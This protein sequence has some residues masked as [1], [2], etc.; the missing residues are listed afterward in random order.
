MSSDPH[1]AGPNA[2]GAAPGQSAKQPAAS[3]APAAPATLDLE[4]EAPEVPDTLPPPVPSPVGTPQ[5]AALDDLEEVDLDLEEVGEEELE[6][7]DL[8][9]SI[10][11]APVDP[12]V[13]PVPKPDAPAAAG[14]GVTCNHCGHVHATDEKFCDACGLRIDKIGTFAVEEDE[15]PLQIDEDGDKLLCRECGVRNRPGLK[16]CIN[17]GGRLIPDEI[18]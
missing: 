14:K 1:K 8:D 16:L 2:P 17:C 12:Q 13:V 18:I 3:K 7:V 4:W 11:A 6:L 5:A 10:E 9:D 15:E